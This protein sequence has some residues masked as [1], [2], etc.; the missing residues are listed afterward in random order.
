MGVDAA[1]LLANVP[2]GDVGVGSDAPAVVAQLDVSDSGIGID[3][4]LAATV[5]LLARE[6]ILEI[7]NGKIEVRAK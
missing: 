6:I 5:K 4:A 2:I 3:D 1:G 7:E